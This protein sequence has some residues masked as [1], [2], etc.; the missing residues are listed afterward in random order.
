LQAPEQIAQVEKAGSF[1]VGVASLKV[2]SHFVEDTATMAIASGG[3]DAD[4]Y[5]E[6]TH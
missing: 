6:E 1:A 4:T 5:E 2:T 3:R